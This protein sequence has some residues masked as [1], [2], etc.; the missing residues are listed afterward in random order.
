MPASL[1]APRFIQSLA[2]LLPRLPCLQRRIHQFDSVSAFFPT[3]GA[4]AQLAQRGPTLDASRLYNCSSART[5]SRRCAPRLQ[6]PSALLVLLSA[7]LALALG[8]PTCCCPA[9]ADPPQSAQPIPLGPRPLLLPPPPCASQPISCT[10]AKPCKASVQYPK[11]GGYKCC[12]KEP[13]SRWEERA[14][15]AGAWARPQPLTTCRLPLP[16]PRG[17][18]GTA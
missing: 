5:A 16:P 4:A 17:L 3:C 15:G 11:A 13:S 2:P 10:P 8:R 1:P 9:A 18:A 14:A 7:T 12:S 6:L